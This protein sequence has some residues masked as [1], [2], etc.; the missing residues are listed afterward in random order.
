MASV[1]KRMKRKVAEKLS[2]NS[3]LVYSPLQEGQF[4]LAKLQPSSSG[5]VRVELCTVH[6]TQP[7]P[8]EVL[9]YIWGQ[10]SN[11]EPIVCNGS[12]ILVRPNLSAALRTL[13]RSA[14]PRLLWIDYICIN[15]SDNQERD[16]QVQLLASIT[17][18]AEHTIVWVGDKG[19]DTAFNKV[20]TAATAFKVVSELVAARE[21]AFQG[22]I[23]PLSR[24]IISNSVQKYRQL[25]S[26]IE[27]SDWRVLEALLSQ[28][29]FQR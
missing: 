19:E 1:F 21:K 28:P 3:K 10:P 17:L 25:L 26:P 24:A 18:A 12:K 8:F 14:E 6:L 29:M 16:L 7:P 27:G 11:D 2:G 13:C 23:V 22:N 20:E 4:R 9:S 15:R 5:Y